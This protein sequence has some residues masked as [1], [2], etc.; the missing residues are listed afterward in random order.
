[1]QPPLDPTPMPSVPFSISLVGSSSR[2]PQLHSQG[3][4]GEGNC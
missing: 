1:M 4:A 3:E 2:W